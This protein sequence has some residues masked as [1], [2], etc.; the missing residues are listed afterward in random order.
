MRGSS[1][2]GRPSR[3]RGGDIAPVG[4][5]T[6]LRR[7]T[8]LTNTPQLGAHHSSSSW[9]AQCFEP[10]LSRITIVGTLYPRIRTTLAKCAS[11]KQS[12]NAVLRICVDRS[13]GQLAGPRHRG[14]DEHPDRRRPVEMEIGRPHLALPDHV[15]RGAHRRGRRQS[16]PSRRAAGEGEAQQ[17]RERRPD[18]CG[19]SKPI[20]VRMKAYSSAVSSS[21]V[22][23]PERPPWPAPMLIF[24]SS[25]LWSVRIALRRAAHLAGSQ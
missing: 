4:Q 11:R 9:K 2:A 23:R 17:Q 15:H 6:R 5:P 20:W 18:Q 25:R 8:R 24:R 22:Q 21:A 1:S 10:V 12:L 14:A 13:P 7:R 3:E 16:G 19:S